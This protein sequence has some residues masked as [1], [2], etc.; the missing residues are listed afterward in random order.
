MIGSEHVHAVGVQHVKR[1]ASTKC[2]K[3]EVLSY[4]K[5]FQ[6]VTISSS[7]FRRRAAARQD[8]LFHHNPSG[9]LLPPQDVERRGE[10]VGSASQLA[11]DPV[12]KSRVVIP[13]GFARPARDL[14]IA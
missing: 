1:C 8:V 9:V 7:A 13:P 10:L 6:V 14:G 4:A 2:K 5:P 12:T 3:Y 11:E